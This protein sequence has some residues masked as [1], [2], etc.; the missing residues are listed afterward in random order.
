MKKYLSRQKGFTLVELLI[1]I[2]LL[3]AL[4]I[5][6]LAAI[7]PFEQLKKGRD[8]S[9]RNSVTEF[10]NASIRFFAIKGELP[11]GLGLGTAGNQ[12]EALDITN[13]TVAIDQVIALGELKTNFTSILSQADQERILVSSTAYD[14]V[15]VCFMP[16]SKSF[17]GDPNSKYSEN[18]TEVTDGSCLSQNADGD[19]CYWCVR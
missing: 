19:P 2:A 8:T 18:G 11:W 4:A 16:E 7:D 9:I 3:G 1:V 17:R 15:T 12:I 14:D 13:E 5:G 10:H 6:L